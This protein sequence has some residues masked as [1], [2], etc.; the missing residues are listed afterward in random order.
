MK[1]L[2]KH[3][4]VYIALALAMLAGCATTPQNPQQAV[5]AAHGTYTVALTAAVKYK[6]LPACG[7]PASPPLCSKPEVVGQLQKADDA[8][9]AALNVAQRV[10]RSS[11]EGPGAVAIAVDNATRAVNAFATVAKALGVN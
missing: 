10:V 5:Y 11:L 3:H 7:K 4:L 6:Q 2:L 1:A 8:A 9:Y